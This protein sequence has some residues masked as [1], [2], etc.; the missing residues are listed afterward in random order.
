MST[1]LAS[2]TLS[3][4]LEGIGAWT[5]ELA[6]WPALRDWLRGGE[7]PPAGSAGKPRPALIP[8]NE[9][10]R[11]P[12]SVLVAVEAACQAVAMGNRDPGQVPSL[13]ACA[14]G[15][16]DILD[17]T[18]TTLAESPAELSPTRFHNSVHNAAAGYWTIATGCHAASSALTALDYTFGASLLEAASL[19]H[20]ETTPVLLVASDGPGCGPLIDVIASRQRFAC[21]LLM[22]PEPSA[23]AVARL[24]IRL[25]GHEP[26]APLSSRA[27][28]LSEGNLSARGS[29]L[30]EMLANGVSSSLRVQ[31]A[32]QLDLDMTMEYLP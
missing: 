17:Y 1:K 7:L 18:C 20:A 19:A 3:L 4:W 22:T 28:S 23:R 12:L 10:R 11:V 21:A 30:L 5:P 9:R 26:D 24:D 32:P 8:A 27:Q 13:F 16:A 31:A 6:D 25:S 14:H 15:D 2:P 29:K